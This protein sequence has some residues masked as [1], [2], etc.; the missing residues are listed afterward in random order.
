[1][2]ECLRPVRVG[3]DRLGPSPMFSAPRRSPGHSSADVLC[4][5]FRSLS[6]ST[7]SLLRRGRRQGVQINEETITNLLML[8]LQEVA[9]PNL[10]VRSFSKRE[11]A[12]TGADWEWWFGSGVGWVGFRLQAK[13]IDF[14]SDSFLHLY[15]APNGVPQYERLLRDALASRPRRLPLY[16]LYMHWERP[17][18]F[19]GTA[20]AGCSML[21][22]VVVQAL[23]PHRKRRLVDLYELTTPWHHLVC[24]ATTV[25]RADLASGVLGT[26]QAL[27]EESYPEEVRISIG[28]NETASVRDLLRGIEP[29]RQVPNYVLA[30]RDGEQPAI[31]DPSLRYVTVFEELPGGEPGE[32]G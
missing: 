11:E 26:A 31:D 21:S 23:A 6:R 20:D 13:V 17:F 22:P 9:S 1:M 19:R 3:R 12:T 24:P 10:R 14:S 32:R 4:G 30:V 29:T 28:P 27:Y 18:P 5:T 16:C 7:W 15:Y 2:V 25:R 8:R